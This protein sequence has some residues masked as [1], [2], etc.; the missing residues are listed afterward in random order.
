M[1]AVAAELGHEVLAWRSVPTDNSSLGA[2]AVRVEPAVEQWFVSARGARHRHL[3]AEAQ[4]FVLRKSVEAAWAAAGLGHDDAYFCSLSARTVVYKGQLTPAQVPLYYA[5]LRSP[6]FRSYMAVAHSRFS[7]NTHPSWGRAQPMRSLAH[8]GEINTLR[9]NRNWMRAREGVMA[10]DALALD[11]EARAKLTP[12]V[13]EWQS[14]SGALDGL[15][16]LL[17]RSGRDVAEAVMMLIPEAWQND[18]LMDPARRDF[19][20]FHSA[21]ME[22]WDGPALVTFT[23][24]RYL[25]CVVFEGRDLCFCV[26][27]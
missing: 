24:G 16:E 5:D 15:L 6:A 18:P 23:D 1:D 27:G 21:V 25:G 9:G 19:Y 11:A 22:P 13:P 3:D 8:N 26:C 20:R 4:L 7:T 2:S 17:T 14:D 12:V 10:C